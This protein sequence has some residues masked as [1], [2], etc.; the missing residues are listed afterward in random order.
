MT[1][2]SIIGSKW[3]WE[4][5]LVISIIMV[6]ALSSMQARPGPKAR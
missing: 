5:R 1:M 6:G 2:S 4:D 3:L